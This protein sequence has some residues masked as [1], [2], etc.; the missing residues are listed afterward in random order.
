MIN[1]K[2]P[3]KTRWLLTMFDG[4]SFCICF[5]RF[6]TF[7]SFLLHFIKNAETIWQ[8]TLVFVSFIRSKQ[9][10]NKKQAPIHNANEFLPQK[11]PTSHL[12]DKYYIEGQWSNCLTVNVLHVELFQKR[13]FLDSKDFKERTFWEQKKKKKQGTTSRIKQTKETP[14]NSIVSFVY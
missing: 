7:A 10:K 6:V 2:V 9:K 14:P 3:K 4:W 1:Y 8:N 5:I 12:Q 11:K 13:R